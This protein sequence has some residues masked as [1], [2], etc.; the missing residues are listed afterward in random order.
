M[1]KKLLLFVTIIAAVRGFAC[2]AGPFPFK[3][4]FSYVCVNEKTG[5]PIWGAAVVNSLLF[6]ECLKPYVN[7][8]DV[9]VSLNSKG[10]WK[11]RF[12]EGSRVLDITV[13]RDSF[14]AE[15][16]SLEGDKY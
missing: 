4:R 5:I 14:G 8:A 2:H 7:V 15:W 11:G 6:V 16:I 10:V 3:N 1:T 12:F 9:Q 13:W